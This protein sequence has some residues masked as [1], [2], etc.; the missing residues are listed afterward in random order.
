MHRFYVPPEQWRPDDPVLENNEAHHCR[1]VLRLDRGDKIVL[2]DGLGNEL[3]AEI[4]S[5]AA[6]TI[7]LRKLSEAQT[8]R[9]RC[10]I[11]L[12]Q[13]I[14]KGKN[15]DLIVQKAVEIGAAEI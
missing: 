11:T 14:P 7:R 8:S 10:R 5:T 6:E 2:F 9:L 12:G 3:T 15:M 1:N 4:V 13:A